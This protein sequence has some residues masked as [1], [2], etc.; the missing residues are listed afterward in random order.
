MAPPSNNAQLRAL[1]SQ[2]T[3]YTG[4]SEK[5]ATKFLR[6][7]G[8]KINDAIDEYYHQNEGAAPATSTLISELGSLFDSLRDDEKDGKNSMELASTMNYLNNELKVNIE[9]AELFVALELLQAPTIGEISREGYVAGWKSS[10]VNASHKEHAKHLRKVIKALPKDAALFKRV[11]KYAF[12]VGR[13]NDQKSLSLDTALIYWDMLFAPPGMPWKNAHRDWLAL[14]KKFLAEKWTRSVNRD[15]WNMVLE[16]AFKSIEDDSV[17]FWN[18]DGA[19]P[20]VIDE[21]VEWCRAN[22]VGKPEKMEVDEA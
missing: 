17:S 4:A 21:F 8:Y 14:W 10:N 16:F 20:S 5:I 9:N 3:S 11:Y 19:W 6:L 7:A 15:M 22:G 18:E 12:V 1:V 2:F 13:E